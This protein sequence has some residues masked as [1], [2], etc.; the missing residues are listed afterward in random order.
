MHEVPGLFGSVGVLL[1]GV[2]LFACG[3]FALVSP[4][5]MFS[6]VRNVARMRRALERIADASETSERSTPG[7]MFGT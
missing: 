5:L 2:C 6:V 7:R 4:F 3:L 1:I